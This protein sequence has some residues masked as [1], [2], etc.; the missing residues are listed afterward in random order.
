MSLRDF[1]DR[2]KQIV[3]QTLY[4]DAEAELDRILVEGALVVHDGQH[5]RIETG[6]ETPAEL[7]ARANQLEGRCDCGA[8]L[9]SS[10]ARSLCRS[11][12]REFRS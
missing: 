1:T 7:A 12:G 5:Y 11:C 10:G 3:S 8:P 4:T 6:A 9:S 2:A